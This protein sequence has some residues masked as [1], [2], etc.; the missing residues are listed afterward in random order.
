MGVDMEPYGP[1]EEGQVIRLPEA[2]A[3]MLVDLG[4]AQPLG[5][6]DKR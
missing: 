2:N 3:T 1:F 4:F 6:T 5:D